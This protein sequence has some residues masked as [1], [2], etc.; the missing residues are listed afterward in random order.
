MKKLKNSEP[1]GNT[2]PGKTDVW[3]MYFFLAI[4]PKFH[5]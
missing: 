1:E 4:K 2:K 5:C 3:R